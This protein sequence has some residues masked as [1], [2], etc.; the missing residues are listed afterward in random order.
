MVYIV[1]VILCGRHGLAVIVP[2]LAVMVSWTC[3]VAV[4]VCGRHG[5]GLSDAVLP[6][7]EAMFLQCFETATTGRALGVLREWPLW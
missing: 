4:I 5:I 1:A 7:T 2:L 6:H 3:F